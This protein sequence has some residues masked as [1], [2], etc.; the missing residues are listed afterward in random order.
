MD[1]DNRLLSNSNLLGMQDHANTSLGVTTSIVVNNVIKGATRSSIQI[2]VDPSKC[3]TAPK[4]IPFWVEL[5]TRKF[6]TVAKHGQDRRRACDGLIRNSLKTDRAVYGRP[7]NGL[8]VNN[9]FLLIII[10]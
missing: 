3:H 8:R 4:F 7:R 1:H 10:D 9:N 5:L 2:L 6:S